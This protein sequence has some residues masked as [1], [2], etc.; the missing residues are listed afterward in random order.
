LYSS[1]SIIR[2]IKSRRM[3]WAGHVAWMGWREMHIGYWW[4]SQK[5]SDHVSQWI[6]LKWILQRQDGVEWTGLIWL[7]TVNSVGLLWTRQWI[8][9]LHKMFR[10]SWGTAQQA[11]PPEGLSSL[12]LVSS[13][14][15]IKLTVRNRKQTETEWKFTFINAL[16]KKFWPMLS[17]EWFSIPLMLYQLQRFSAKLN[18]KAFMYE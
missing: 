9:G 3:R 10:S 13:L 4:E 12:K 7:R 14:F 1:P 6:I 8:F 2:M 18:L 5:E 16:D 11:A 15:P 17:V